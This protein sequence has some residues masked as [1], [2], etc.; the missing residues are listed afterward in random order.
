MSSVVSTPD[1]AQTPMLCLHGT[2]RVCWPDG[3]TLPLTGRHAGESRLRMLA[4]LAVEQDGLSRAAA[5]T[6][7]WPDSSPSAAR[8]NLRQKLFQL[9]QLPLLQALPLAQD[10]ERL[11]WPV[12]TDLARLS[13][14]TPETAPLAVADVLDAT[15]DPL[16]D[17]LEEGSRFDEW[18]LPWRARARRMWRDRLLAWLSGD[19][20]LPETRVRQ[21][22]DRALA[23]EPFDEA[24]VKQRLR[25]LAR[26]EG[27]VAARLAYDDWSERVRDE[28]GQAAS[29][30]LTPLL[31]APTRAAALPLRSR[32]APPL[33]VLDTM[34]PFFGREAELARLQATLGPMTGETGSRLLCVWGPPGVGKTRLALQWAAATQATGQQ[35]AIVRM[36]SLDVHLPEQ[37]PAAAAINRPAAGAAERSGTLLRAIADACGLVLDAADLP[38]DALVAALNGSQRVIVLDN[39]EHRLADRDVLQQLMARTAVRWLVTSRARLNLHAEQVLPLAGLPFLA[40]PGTRPA[41]QDLL[42][43]RA[44]LT[45]SLDIP[46][47]RTVTELCRL[48]QGHPLVLTLAAR[49]AR[50]RGLNAALVALRDDLQVL[51]ETDV[52][53]MQTAWDPPRHRSLAGAFAS[54]LSSLP[55]RLR[56]AVPRLSLL[57]GGFT[58]E[59][60]SALLPA[61]TAGLLDALVASSVL[62]F[63]PRGA[64]Y[65]WHPF[66]RDFALSALHADAAAW[67]A[68]RQALALHV[69]STLREGAKGP[70]PEPTADDWTQQHWPA[71]QE[72]WRFA[73]QDVRHDWWPVLA[74]AIAAH[75][76]RHA[77][78]REGYALLGECPPETP[79]SHAHPTAEAQAQAQVLRLRARLAH[80][81]DSEATLLCV[82]TA[83]PVLAASHDRPGQR[84]CL[85]LRAL[86]LWRSGRSTQAVDCQRRALRLCTAAQDQAARAMLLD[87]LGLAVLSLGQT[88]RAMDL[89]AQAL[90]LNEQLGQTHQAVQNVVNLSLDPR[91]ERGSAARNLARRALALAREIGYANHVP[92]ALAALAWAH[93]RMGESALALAVGLDAAAQAQALGDAFARSWSLGASARA[94]RLLGRTKE[95]AE[96]ALHAFEAARSL[97][98]TP[99]LLMHLSFAAAWALD[100]GDASA[101]L[102]L[103]RLCLQRPELNAQLR[104]ELQA[105][106]NSAR[107][108]LGGA[109]MTDRGADDP[110]VLGE[111]VWRTAVPEAMG[112]LQQHLG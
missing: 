103:A 32:D 1:A 68:S 43:E 90:S 12:P 37:N 74:E 14:L 18:L 112:L 7:L 82:D 13:A 84:D 27:T 65:R 57:R 77:A 80:W 39:F 53:S 108:A 95:A 17:G 25:W 28:F 41:A 2:L 87:G 3:Q 109:A 56:E 73:R 34:Q 72:A 47:Q 107:H 4:M 38:L 94:A 79:P 71:L 15:A 40:A 9:R 20:D 31:S 49:L 16:L 30:D 11:R 110:Q 86:V 64:R 6:W 106:C 61:P 52:D 45:A 54:V 76:E 36:D 101:A 58:E 69:V 10:E 42:C 67:R 102:R 48:A 81:F 98:E 66:L 111:L 33:A 96:L 85:R 44:E 55:P 63:D 8:S 89:F 75:C 104:A 100:R 92:H 93:L 22:I 105:T 21:L 88:A 97:R 46:T 78:Y 62:D 29:F 23:A 60:A 91:P 26:H 99:P 50:R 24:V 83:E 5:C 59:L 70:A 19:V 35:V 51:D